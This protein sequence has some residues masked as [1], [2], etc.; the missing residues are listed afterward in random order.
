MTSEMA[1]K[2]EV[3]KTYS[4]RSICDDQ[5]IVRI[6]VASRTRCFITTT[7]GKRLGVRDWTTSEPEL[8]SEA[9]SPWGHYS[10]SPTIV[11]AEDRD[12]CPL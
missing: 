11:A 7:K 9:V 12:P 10:M 1:H 8:S 2:F 6:T 5:C 4:T 3:G